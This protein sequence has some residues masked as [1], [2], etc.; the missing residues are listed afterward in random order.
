MNKQFSYKSYEIDL[1]QE[2]PGQWKA[3]IRRTDGKPI[4]TDPY[5]AA[6]IPVLSTMLFHSA[7]AAI[8]EAKAMIDRG[9][10]K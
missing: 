8:A 9:H 7:E 10:M 3:H 6:N 1:R 2:S 4:N 5:G